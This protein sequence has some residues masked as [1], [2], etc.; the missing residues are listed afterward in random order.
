MSRN[1]IAIG[2]CTYKR[3]EQLQRCLRSLAGIE[4]PAAAAV[5]III[6][7][8]DPEGSAVDVV[9]CFRRTCDVPVYYRV[10]AQR[11]IAFAR[12]AVLKQAL[13]LDITE[14]AF[15]DDDEF[16]DPMWLINLW[17]YYIHSDADVVRGYVKTIYPPGTPA[18]ITR[19]GFHQAPCYET[20][21]SFSWAG[22]GNVLFNVYK[23]AIEQGLVFDVGFGLTG[24][25]DADFFQRAHHNGAVI[26][27]V[28]N[29]VVYEELARDRMSTLYLLKRKW[30]VKN[31]K[32][33]SLT[34][35]KRIT[36]LLTECRLMFRAVLFLLRDA[37]RGRHVVVGRLVEVVVRVARISALLG[38][39]ITWNEYK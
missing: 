26:R 34:P 36:L 16:A 30:R 8:N 3:P 4:R 38:V 20:G 6:A 25:E 32:C 15:I 39:H 35:G 9:D 12:N 22:T 2:L 24:G 10:E 11:G 28:E 5:G 21:T 31:K 17:D 23:L 33:P 19:G 7:D 1:S 14:L 37:G 18:W 13:E 29:A 27:F